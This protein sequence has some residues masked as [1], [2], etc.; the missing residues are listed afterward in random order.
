[1]KQ[2]RP[3]PTPITRVIGELADTYCDYCTNL[4]I[5]WSCIDTLWNKEL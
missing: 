2:H 5:N 3:H 1:M 4:N